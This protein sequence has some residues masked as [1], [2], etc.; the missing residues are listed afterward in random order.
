MV[1]PSKAVFIVARLIMELDLY[2]TENPLRMASGDA[3]DEACKRLNIKLSKSVRTKVM[4]QLE[5]SF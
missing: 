3:V 2:T 1:A 5:E 4:E